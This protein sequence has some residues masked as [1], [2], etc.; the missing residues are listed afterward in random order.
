MSSLND[1]PGIGPATAT[2][3]GK[4]GITTAE[5]LSVADVA[6]L[7]TVR[8]ISEAR[9]KRYIATAKTLLIVPDS[10]VDASAKA[11][12][13]KVKATGDIKVTETKAKKKT[14]GLKKVKVEMV[15]GADTEK[16]KKDKKKSAKG[17]DKDKDKDKDK[18]KSKAKKKAA[19]KKKK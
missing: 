5:A 18:A 6:M 2:E 11:P 8:G 7:T 12:G 16:A 19:K 10:A 15:N 1:I 3:L 13:A 9:A 17:K 4:I 14:A